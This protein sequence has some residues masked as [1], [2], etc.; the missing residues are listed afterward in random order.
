MVSIHLASCQPS[1]QPWTPSREHHTR[2]PC[3]NPAIGYPIRWS[4]STVTDNIA[5]GTDSQ[6]VVAKM[7]KIAPFQI[8]NSTWQEASYSDASSEQGRRWSRRTEKLSA[9]LQLWHFCRSSPN[10]WWRHKS[11]NILRRWTWTWCLGS[12]PPTASSIRLS[13]Q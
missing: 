1:H 2:R 13:R 10:D 6:T 11:L 8:F 4:A 3:I 7:W 9:N 5:T 12:S